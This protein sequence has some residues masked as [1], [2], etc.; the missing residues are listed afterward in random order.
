MGGK[1]PV[2]Q[3]GIAN[4]RTDCLKLACL[5]CAD[6]ANIGHGLSQGDV[7]NQCYYDQV[8]VW[9][10]LEEALPSQTETA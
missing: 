2:D 4:W 3:V 6:A 5:G 10:A 8:H 9:D 1:D 7:M